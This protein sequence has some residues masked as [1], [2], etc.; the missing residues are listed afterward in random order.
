[1]KQQ[2]LE[3]LRTESYS[4]AFFSMYPIENYNVEDFTTYRGLPGVLSSVPLDNTDDLCIYLDTALSG[5]NAISNLYLGLDPYQLWCS[6]GREE[7]SF[8]AALEEKLFPYMTAHPDIT[9]EVL[10]PYQR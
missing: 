3:A 1:M 6:F 2:D 10:L 4:C 8:V 5:S 9:F 7:A